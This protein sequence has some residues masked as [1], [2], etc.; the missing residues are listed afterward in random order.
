M[1]LVHFGD[2]QHFVA[3]A[4]RRFN[5]D[6]VV[7]F[8]RRA[9]F[10][11]YD[12]ASKVRRLKDNASDAFLEILQPTDVGALLSRLPDCHTLVTTGGKASEQLASLL[13]SHSPVSVPAPGGF[14]DV[15]AFGRE[16][17]WWRMPSTSRAYPLPLAA[18]ASAYAQLWPQPLD[19]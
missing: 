7:E 16:L 19:L 11:F 5:Y 4:G 8:C 18:K 17:C 14:T 13:G 9:G 2:A 1:G 12:T 15:N 6:S 10:A 3:P